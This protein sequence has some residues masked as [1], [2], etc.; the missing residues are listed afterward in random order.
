M[1]VL[2]LKVFLHVT[3]CSYPSRRR[4]CLVHGARLSAPWLHVIRLVLPHKVPSHRPACGNLVF[5]LLPVCSTTLIENPRTG[6]SLWI[7]P[8]LLT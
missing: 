2:F 7:I 3:H 5:K 4:A 8:Q 1:V 6:A